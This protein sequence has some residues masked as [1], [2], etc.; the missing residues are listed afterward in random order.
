MALS[1]QRSAG[2]SG[3]WR[4][5]F[6]IAAAALDLAGLAASFLPVGASSCTGQATAVAQ[7][8]PAGPVRQICRAAPTIVAFQSALPLFG[9]MIALGLVPL[10]TLKIRGRWPSAVSALL[11]AVLQLL[12]FGAFL[13]WV[14][15]WLCTVAAAIT[16]P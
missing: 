9:L 11:Q 1:V 16:G 7:E 13:F 2:R 5:L 15:A 3:R 12:G 14:P 10:L 8:H 4:L 6:S